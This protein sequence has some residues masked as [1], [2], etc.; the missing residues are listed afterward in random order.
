MNETKPVLTVTEAADLLGISRA[1]A[2]QLVA[3][4]QI[5]AVHLGHRIVVPRQALEALLATAADQSD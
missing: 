3:R 1:L 4:G 5:P 2:Y